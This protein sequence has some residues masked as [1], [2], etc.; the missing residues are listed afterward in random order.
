M[1]VCDVK[2]LLNNIDFSSFYDHIQKNDDDNDLKEE[3]KKPLQCEWTSYANFMFKKTTASK[4]FLLK[5]IKSN[6]DLLLKDK[7]I[8]VCDL[9]FENDCSKLNEFTKSSSSSSSISKFLV[10]SKVAQFI[11]EKKF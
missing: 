11:N 2:H 4:K 3:S 8:I 10:E 1:Y 7:K 6:D 5:M 9:L